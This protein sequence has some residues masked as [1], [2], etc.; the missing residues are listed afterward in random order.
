[1]EL[2]PQFSFGIPL[3]G[4]VEEQ[5]AV[6]PEH[7]LLTSSQ[8]KMMQERLYSSNIDS[9][10]ESYKE[11]EEENEVLEYQPSDIGTSQFGTKV[12]V[13]AANDVQDMDIQAW[14]QPSPI[15]YPQMQEMPNDPLSS[16]Q[17][18]QNDER[19][20]DLGFSANN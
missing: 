4:Q 12:N 3:V 9:R 15:A 14:P 16:N 20:E 8:K 6:P 18:P 13:S 10:T 19:P 11:Q 2:V 17:T 5:E 1:M 7:S